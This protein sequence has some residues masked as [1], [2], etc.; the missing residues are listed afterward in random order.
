MPHTVVSRQ[1]WL[2]A[3]KQLLEDE[4]QLTE[5][6]DRVSA[7][8]RALPWVKVE[9]GYVFDTPE[10]RKTLADLFDGRSQLIV[11]HFM[12]APE[13]DA[14]CTGCSFGADHIDGANQHLAHHDVT[15]VAISRA[16]LAKLQAYGRRMGWHFPWASSAGTDFNYDFQVSFRK[17][18]LASGKVVYN[19]ETVALG[20]GRPAMEDLPGASVFFKDQDG[21]VFH[22]Y[23]SYGRGNEEVIGAY[24]LLDMT[25]KGRNENGPHH[26]L[27]DWVKRHDEYDTVPAQS[28]CHET[29]R[30][31]ARARS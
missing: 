12:F 1:D 14:G 19:Y 8:R 13:W 30:A 4:K 31:D 6:R 25:P 29:A 22:T 15:F 17:E 18:D 16:P 7:A 27:M 28:C 24:M 20:D 23:S 11:Q 2:A 10:G 3:R 9:K 21:T 5:A 26:N